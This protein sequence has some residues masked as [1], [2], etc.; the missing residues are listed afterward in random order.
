MQIEITGLRRKRE[1]DKVFDL[2]GISFAR[3]PRDFFVARWEAE[4][5]LR[6]WHTRVLKLN[7]EIVS[8][9]QIFPKTMFINGKE[10]LIAGIGNVAT[11]PEHRKKGYATRLLK[12]TNRFLKEKGFSLAVLFT[13]INRFYE[14]VGYFTV[15]LT[16]HTVFADKHKARWSSNVHVFRPED[17]R[18]IVNFYRKCAPLYSG[19]YKRDLRNW[20]Y[21]PYYHFY[22][23]Y[24][25]FLVHAVSGQINGYLRV[26]RRG[27]ESLE[28]VEFCYRNS[29]VFR[30]LL[31]SLIF[32][33]GV[34]EILLNLGFEEYHLIENYSK[35]TYP[36]AGM[37]FNILLPD[38]FESLTGLKPDKKVIIEHFEKK[39]KLFFPD[40][41]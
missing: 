35:H 25:L 13:S 38:K 7:G 34:K 11:V 1:L 32:R 39:G 4:K 22:E 37:M 23:V 40:A 20:L 12:A 33:S 27:K 14:K 36:S 24:G 29:E 18:G 26:S 28:I 2:L 3:T 16:Y 6:L 10:I 17:F 15:P 30:E 8:I 19:L 41:F 9:V 21:Q 5:S 31:D